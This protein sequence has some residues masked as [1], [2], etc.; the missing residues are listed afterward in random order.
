MQQINVIYVC[1]YFAIILALV[2]PL[3]VYIAK[4]YDN[5]LQVNGLIARIE[6]AIYTLCRIDP[7]KD[8]NWKDYLFAMLLFNFIGLMFLYCL[9]RVQGYLPLNP[10]HFVNINPILAFNTAVSFVTNTNW[11]A[12]AGGETSLSYLTQM[13]GLTVQ[14]FLSA[15]TGMSLLIAFIRGIIRHETTLLGNFWC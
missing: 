12:Y 2:R 14:N 8:M 1:I 9:Q 13:L 15:A 6:H 4:I 3:G 7:M 10:Q 11:Q 5:T